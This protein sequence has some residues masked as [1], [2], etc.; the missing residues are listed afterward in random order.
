MTGLCV[1][2][3]RDLTEWNITFWTSRKI[4]G[5]K[6]TDVFATTEELFDGKQSYNITNAVSVEDWI[7]FTD[8]R[9]K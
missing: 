1:F 2:C 7:F 3:V 6:I 8:V 5:V 9:S 4:Y